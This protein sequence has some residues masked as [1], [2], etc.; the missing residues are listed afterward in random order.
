[1]GFLAQLFGFGPK[2]DYK[3][4]VEKGA[5]II[6]VRTP[7]EFSSGHIRNCT[8]IPLQLIQGKLSKIKKDKPVILCCASGARSG[9][10]SRILKSKG[11]E[12]YNGGSWSSL[13]SKLN[14]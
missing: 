6:D 4:L 8:N 13:N 14:R 1:M 10:A 3:E 5:I 2:V 11:F 7:G 12:A 9:A